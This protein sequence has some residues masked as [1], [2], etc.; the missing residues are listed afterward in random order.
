MELQFDSDC[1]PVIVDAIN[2]MTRK[3]WKDRITIEQALVLLG[4]SE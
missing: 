3:E 4:Q 1:P 2:K